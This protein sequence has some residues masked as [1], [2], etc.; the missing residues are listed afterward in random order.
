M[1]EARQKRTKNWLQEEL[2]RNKLGYLNYFSY[3]CNINSNT[4]KLHYV[5]YA[6]KKDG[7][8]KVGATSQPNIRFKKYRS[9]TIIQSFD[10]PWKCGDKE[11]ELQYDYFKERDNSK[12]YA[13]T[14][15]M[16]KS[17][18]GKQFSDETRKKI[19]NSL[20]GSTPWNKGI[21]RSNETKQKIK[22]KLSGKRGCRAQLTND[23]VKFVRKNYYIAKNQFTKI[24]D[25]LYTLRELAN[26][27]NVSSASIKAVILRK[28]Y[29]HVK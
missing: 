22:E 11:I 10:C 14:L 24:P 21:P 23:D 5:Y 18:V 13:V 20:M 6:I 7:T 17:N 16:C 2:Y 3:I 19:S 15:K 1:L 4:M 8:P 28:S 9:A 25:G 12:H 29:K 26:M 27:F